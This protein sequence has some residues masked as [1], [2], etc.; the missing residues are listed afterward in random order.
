M[1]LSETLSED[2]LRI[3]QQQPLIHNITNYV[4]MGISANALLAIG[5][6]PLMSSEP[7][8]MEE[9]SAISNA[10]VIN[11]GCLERTQ[12]DAMYK[13]TE[14]AAAS[15]KPWI[16]DPVGVGISRLRTETAL[17]LISAYA[18]NVIRGNASEILFLADARLD[19]GSPAVPH[20]ADAADESLAAVGP[21][22][23]LA[24]ETGAVISISGP[25]DYITDG[26]TVVSIA[27]GSPL[28]PR[29]TAMG[30]TAT[31]VTAAF[32]AVDDNNLN[33]AAAAMA[34]MG[35]AGEIAARRSAGP[36]SFAVNFLDTLAGLDAGT[37]S[38]ILRYEE[39][40]A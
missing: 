9:I 30:C 13:A 19:N 32:L 15:G 28:M 7:A 27:N 38:E 26:R 1:T 23:E 10:L 6:S 35:T 31:A 4:A 21:A 3:R 17:D 2:C 11:L 40:S 29:V 5:A 24:C 34:V 12:I 25:T 8:E 14:A 36:G 39:K 22:V 16:L 20:G 37:A 33:A 18:P